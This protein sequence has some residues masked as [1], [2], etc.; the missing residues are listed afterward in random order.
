MSFLVQNPKVEIVA[1]CD[2]YQPSIEKKALSWLRKLK[3]MTITGN[4]GR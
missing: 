2:I 3:F 1:L 4:T